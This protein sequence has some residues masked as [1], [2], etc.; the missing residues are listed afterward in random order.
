MPK[1][2]GRYKI[3]RV[4]GSGGMG[5]VYLAE[6][7]GMERPVVVK[8]LH[9]ELT[10]GSP[11]AVE[12]FKREAR[13]AARLN[14]PHVVQVHVFGTTD[15]G[16]LFLAMEYVDGHTL[17]DAINTQGRFPEAR[18][19]KIMDAICGAAETKPDCAYIGQRY[20][21]AEKYLGGAR[22]PEAQPIDDT[23]G[24]GPA[25]CAGPRRAS[26]PPATPIRPEPA[27]GDVIASGRW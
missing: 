1:Q 23:E 15:S 17:A 7:I 8:I 20:P 25:L 21:G 13:A 24:S 4:I 18:A 27:T 3:R 6:Q 16:Q 11:T 2:I 26:A 12:R 19:L 5:T 10:A 9:P 14:H 22:G